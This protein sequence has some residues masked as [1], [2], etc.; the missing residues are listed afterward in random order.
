[1]LLRILKPFILKDNYQAKIFREGELIK[2]RNHDL[3]IRLVRDGLAF[4]YEPSGWGT[5]LEEAYDWCLNICMLLPE[6]SKL[7]EKVRPNPCWKYQREEFI[8]K[9]LKD[10]GNGKKS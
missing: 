9:F 2:V 10:N 6:H 8:Q 1:M 3:A 4:P 5:D 7:C